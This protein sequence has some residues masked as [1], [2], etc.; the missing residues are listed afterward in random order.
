M[1]PD[2]AFQYKLH[3]TRCKTKCVVLT[4]D[5]IHHNVIWYMHQNDIILI[6]I[7]S[8]IENQSQLPKNLVV[9][10]NCLKK[11]NPKLQLSMQKEIFS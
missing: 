4:R 7:S 2:I 5:E 1:E 3:G 9:P 8:T 11:L 6:F 10:R